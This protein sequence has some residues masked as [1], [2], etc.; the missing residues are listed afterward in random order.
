MASTRPQSLHFGGV[1]AEPGDDF[2][3]LVRL[4]DVPHFGFRFD[5]RGARTGGF[6]GVN[7]QGETLPRVDDFDEEGE[8][9]AVEV[10]ADELLAVEFDELAESFAFERTVFDDADGVVAV[11]DFPCF[12]DGRAVRRHV[13]FQDGF[14]FVSAPHDFFVDGFEYQRVKSICVNHSVTPRE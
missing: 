14:K 5:S 1:V 10:V 6:I 11:D 8:L 13:A 12:A 7:L 3:A 9:A 4:D 2:R